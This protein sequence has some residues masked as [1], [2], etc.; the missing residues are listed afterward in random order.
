M[1]KYLYDFCYSDLVDPN[2]DD[3]IDALPFEED[4]HACFPP[5]GDPPPLPENTLPSFSAR[6]PERTLHAGSKVLAESRNK[7]SPSCVE[8]A[9]NGGPCLPQ[10]STSRGSMNIV[11]NPCGPSYTGAKVGSVKKHPSGD[12]DSSSDENLF[13]S[14]ASPVSGPEMQ[15]QTWTFEEGSLV[16]TSPASCRSVSEAGNRGRKRQHSSSDHSITSNE[17]G[18]VTES[19]ISINDMNSRLQDGDSLCQKPRTLSDSS[20]GSTEEVNCGQVSDMSKTNNSE[21]GRS[22]RVGDSLCGPH[23]FYCS[24]E[25]FISDVCT[26]AFV[27][28]EHDSDGSGYVWIVSPQAISARPQLHTLVLKNYRKITDKSLTCL[29]RLNSLRYLDVSG[30]SVTQRGVLEFRLKRPDVEVVSDYKDLPI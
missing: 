20:S 9:E 24:T 3:D 14:V 7:P 5:P 13:S 18:M 17:P 12:S 27:L 30:T 4:S 11:L 1:L 26:M 29:L 23:L 15:K 22:L 16:P 8:R 25:S 10:A 28:K 21:Q 2:N 19:P 6:C